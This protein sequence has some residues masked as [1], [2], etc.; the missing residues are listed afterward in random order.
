[1]DEPQGKW[2]YSEG[3]RLGKNRTPHQRCRISVIFGKEIFISNFIK[4][5]VDFFGS[6]FS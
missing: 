6:V 5:C 2:F 3:V 1:M 4:Y